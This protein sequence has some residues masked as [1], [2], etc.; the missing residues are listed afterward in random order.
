MK[1]CRAVLGSLVFLSVTVFAETTDPA[2]ADVSEDT[3]ETP[4][5]QPSQAPATATP[6][7]N[8][9]DSSSA[10]DNA[11]EISR[12]EHKRAVIRR[13]LEDERAQPDYTPPPPPSLFDQISR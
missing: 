1:L 12:E 8:T 10:G 13:V 5:A 4:A 9:Q 3:I 11:D 2:L 6:A 7:E